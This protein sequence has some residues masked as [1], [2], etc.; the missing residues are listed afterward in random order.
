MLLLTNVMYLV[1]NDVMSNT[2]TVHFFSALERSHP[3]SSMTKYGQ[4]QW[5]YSC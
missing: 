3:Q 1:S 4:Q 2:R 5:D